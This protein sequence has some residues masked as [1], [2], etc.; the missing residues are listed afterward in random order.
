[1]HPLVESIC[2]FL[3]ESHMYVKDR[4]GLA[5]II[6]TFLIENVKEKEVRNELGKAVMQFQFPNA[7]EE[8]LLKMWEVAAASSVSEKGWKHEPNYEKVVS[9]VLDLVRNA[10][11][12]AEETAHKLEQEQQEKHEEN[13]KIIAL[14]SV[15]D[16]EI[17]SMELAVRV[18][19]ALDNAG[20]KRLGELVSHNK[21]EVFKI[22][23]LGKAAVCQI[24]TELGKLDLFLGMDLKGW[25]D[26]S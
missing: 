16:K 24:E 17:S 8:T 18:L 9:S 10:R 23:G 26:R 14:Y 12:K 7:D 3:E 5:G 19:N 4:E 21:A 1:M 13:E 2:K 6:F 11:V 25:R 22:K 20:L 15:L